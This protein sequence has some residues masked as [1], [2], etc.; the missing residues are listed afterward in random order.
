MAALTDE[1]FG[2]LWSAL[3]SAGKVDRQAV[4]DALAKVSNYEGVTGNMKFQEGSGDPIKS[5][6]I[7]QVKGDKFVWFANANP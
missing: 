4:R 3:K 1:S 7:L 2:L 5:A 6:V